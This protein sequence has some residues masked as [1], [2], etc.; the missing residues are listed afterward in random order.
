MATLV[1]LRVLPSERGCSEMDTIGG[2]RPTAVKKE[3]GARL[4]TPSSEMVLT[5]AIARGMMLPMR[6]L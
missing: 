1:S 5:Q 6:S 4:A 3:M 2:F